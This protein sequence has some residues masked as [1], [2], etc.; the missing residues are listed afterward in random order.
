[1]ENPEHSILIS[2]HISSDLENFC[3]DF[4]LIS[5]GRIVLHEDVE[6]LKDGYGIVH[7]LDQGLQQG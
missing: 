3:D 5:S 6:T 4:Y 1:M 7:I 2:S